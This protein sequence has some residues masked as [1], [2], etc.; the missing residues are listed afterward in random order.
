MTAPG[1][2]TKALEVPYSEKTIEVQGVAIHTLRWSNPG[3][4]GLILI[5]GGAAHANW[6]TFLA[7]FFQNDYDV[8]AIDL[9]GHGDS[10]R[11]ESYPRETWAAEVIAVAEDAKFPGPPILVGHSMGGLVAIVTAALYGEKLAG[12]IIVDSPVKKPNPESAAARQKSAFGPSRVY[13]D[14]EAGVSRF[15]LVPGQPCEMDFIIDHVA[16]HSLVKTADG[17]WTW[18]FDPAVF[19]LSMHD[20]MADFLS[21]VRTRVAMLRGAFSTVVPPETAQEM[22][23]LLARSAPLVEIPEAHHHLILDQPLAFVAATRALLADWQHSK[24]SKPGPMGV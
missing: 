20:R 21:H 10:G 16:R 17:T 18:K 13:A 11:R 23:D 7:P 9:S 15:R 5:H 24:P 8:I 2:F 1:W 19:S 14:F 4:P 3:A 12:A 6:W 22:Y